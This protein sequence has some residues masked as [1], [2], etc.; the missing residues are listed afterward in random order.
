MNRDRLTSFF[1]SFA[2][3][4]ISGLVVITHGASSALAQRAQEISEDDGL[5]V[6]IKH[7]PDWEDVRDS[8]V[9]LTDRESLRSQVGQ[10]NFVDLIDFTGGTEAVT[11]I[12]PEGRLVIVEFATPQAAAD[13]DAKILAVL[14]GLPDPGAVYRRIGNYSV[15]VLDPSSTDAAAALIDTVKYEKNIQWL[16]EDPF[17]LQKLERYFVSTT[18]DIF[19]STVLWIVGGFGISIVLGIISGFVF[20]RMREQQRSTRRTFSD[21]GGLVRLNLDELSEN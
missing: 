18:R 10:R 8:T 4:L 17:L 14:A 1:R 11:A 6:L 13:A 9:F 5:P 21:A 3:V 16:G 2:I 7:L 19:I 12:Y 20:F 15:F